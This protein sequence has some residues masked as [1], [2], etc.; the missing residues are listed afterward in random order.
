MKFL[1]VTDIPPCENYT[2]GLVLNRLVQ[3]LPK[4]DIVFCAIVNPQLTPQIPKYLDGIKRLILQKPVERVFGSSL[5]FIGGAISFLYEQIQSIRVYYLLAPKIA[6]YAKSQNVDGIWVVLQGQ[7]MV[8]LACILPKLLSC[9]LYTQVWDPFGWWLRAHKVDAWTQ[10]ILQKK[11]S[12]AVSQSISCATASIGMSEEYSKR[13]NVKNNPV[14]AGLPSEFALPPANQP[15]Q[16]SDFIIGMAGQIYAKDGWN[17]LISALNKVGWVING[18]NVRIKLLG[19]FVNFVTQSPLCIEYYGWRNQNETIR[20][21]EECDI[22]YLPYWFSSEFEEECKNSFPSK[23]VTYFA[24]GRPV[25]CHAPEYSS[26]AQYILRNNAGYVC[27]SIESEEIIKVLSLGLEDN[28][29]YQAYAQNGSSCF[30]R[31]FTLDAMKKSF[32]VFIGT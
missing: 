20:I 23:L 17:S 4:E 2:A 22:L 21:L 26:P 7:T 16:S 12:Q 1:L 3:F 10:R 14:I 6:M 27:N 19:E 11:F 32:R 9:P 8:R 31:D 24:T 13:F 25:I 18:R 30:K 29:R 15:H 28:F 5:P